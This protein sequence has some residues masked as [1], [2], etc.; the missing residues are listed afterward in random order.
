MIEKLNIKEDH[1][2][3]IY[4]FKSKTHKTGMTQPHRHAELEMNLVIRGSAEYIL[5]NKSYKLTRGSIV[6]LFPDQEHLL[7]KTDKEFEVYVA[8]FKMKRF[9]NI[10]LSKEKYNML[11]ESNPK[12]NFCRRLSIASTE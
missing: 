6:W 11:L 7:C 1:E 10:L 4:L 5:S 3:F 8:V 2:G 12:G 9:N